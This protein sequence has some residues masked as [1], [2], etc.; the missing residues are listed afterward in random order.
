MLKQR[1]ISET[2]IGLPLHVGPI[3]NFH[4]AGQ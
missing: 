2:Y 3:M 1:F 4:G